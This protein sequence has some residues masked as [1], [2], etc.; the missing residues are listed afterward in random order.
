M[1]SVASELDYNQ[2]NITLESFELPNNKFQ[3]A[4]QLNTN[5]KNNMC[6]NKNVSNLPDKVLKQLI[7]GMDMKDK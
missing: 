2:E 5:E 3:K 1:F 7:I 6:L 4:K